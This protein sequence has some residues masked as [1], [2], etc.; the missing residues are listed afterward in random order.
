MAQPWP[1]R[2]GATGFLGG[3]ELE[4]A[5]GQEREHLC[6]RPASPVPLPGV[7]CHHRAQFFARRWARFGSAPLFNAEF[8]FGAPCLFW[9]VRLKQGK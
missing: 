1:D 8:L 6:L 2:K 4:G 3:R 9:R 7:R 5:G